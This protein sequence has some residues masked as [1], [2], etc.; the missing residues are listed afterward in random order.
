MSDHVKQYSIMIRFY[1]IVLK[2]HVKMLYWDQT[3]EPFLDFIGKDSGS[4]IMGRHFG[5][6]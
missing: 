3:D 1:L 2:I 6:V 5:F 4:S